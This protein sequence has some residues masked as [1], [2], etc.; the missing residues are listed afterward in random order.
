MLDDVVR[1]IGFRQESAASRHFFG[2]WLSLP[3]RHE[4]R[5]PW[6]IAAYVVRQFEAGHRT[7]HVYIGEKRPNF[8]GLSAEYVQRIIG[9]PDLDDCKTGIGQRVYG[10]HTYQNVILGNEDNN[11]RPRR[12]A[13]GGHVSKM[14][15]PPVGCRYRIPYPTCDACT[16]ERGTRTPLLGAVVTSAAGR[17]VEGGGVGRSLLSVVGGLNRGAGM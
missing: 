17:K 11:G 5:N 16:E 6:P 12:V 15:T 4:K 1:L 9:V 3:R 13:R 2:S 7:G 10:H 8:L 14:S